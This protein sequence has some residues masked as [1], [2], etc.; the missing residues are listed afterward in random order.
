MI[1]ADL[2]RQYRCQPRR[3]W[4][5]YSQDAELFRFELRD[6]E[7]ERVWHNNTTRDEGNNVSANSTAVVTGMGQAEQIRSPPVSMNVWATV[8]YVAGGVSGFVIFV[9]LISYKIIKHN[10][11]NSESETDSVPDPTTST[12]TAL[13][14]TSS[15]GEEESIRTPETPELSYITTISSF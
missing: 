4:E 12:S 9:G 6:G 2:A 15:L 8:G 5:D 14:D 3:D 7:E 13:S 10:T 1:K 11:K